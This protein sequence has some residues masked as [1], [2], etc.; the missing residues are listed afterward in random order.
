MV[1]GGGLENSPD[2]KLLKFPNQDIITNRLVM[3]FLLMRDSE[4]IFFYMQQCIDQMI[5]ILE[6]YEACF[7]VDRVY[8]ALLDCKSKLEHLEYGTTQK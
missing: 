2:F 4:D 7:E 1:G 5:D 6:E 3:A 8:C